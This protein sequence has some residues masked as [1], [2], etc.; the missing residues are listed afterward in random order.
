MN[1]KFYRKK[2]GLTMQQVADALGITTGA[3][4]QWEVNGIFPEAKRLSALAK[5]YNC[6]IDELLSD[7][8][9]EDAQ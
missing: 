9:P 6:T 4:A 5:L 2:A 8:K 1:F 3:I 7:E